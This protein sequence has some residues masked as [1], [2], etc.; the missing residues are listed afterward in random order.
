LK[1]PYNKLIEKSIQKWLSKNHRGKKQPSTFTQKKNKHKFLHA[2][3][4]SHK[5]TKK[6]NKKTPK[7]FYTKPTSK[8]Y[9]AKFCW[10]KPWTN[11]FS[12][13]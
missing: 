10:I 1:N 7:I 11:N 3:T 9:H 13:K 4:N 12:T 6:I 8:N 5:I 2:E